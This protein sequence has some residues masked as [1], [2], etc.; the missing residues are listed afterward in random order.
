MVA[1]LK[2]K[3]DNVLFCNTWLF[4]LYRINESTNLKHETNSSLTINL[5]F[6]LCY[7]GLLLMNKI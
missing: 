5:N 6:Y 1:S 7:V 2:F 3:S 4:V